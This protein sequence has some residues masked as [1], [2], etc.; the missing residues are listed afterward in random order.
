MCIRDRVSWAQALGI[1]NPL[2]RLKCLPAGDEGYLVD[3]WGA[4]AFCTGND[5]VPLPPRIARYVRIKTVSGHVAAHTGNAAVLAD[6]PLTYLL[7]GPARQVDSGRI[8]KRG[9]HLFLASHSPI[10]NHVPRHS[11]Q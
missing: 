9:M 8:E 11:A 7:H 5:G 3:G 10:I 4:R 6:V 1:R 2:R